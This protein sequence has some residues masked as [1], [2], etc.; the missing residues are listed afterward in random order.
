[1]IGIV[2]VEF[3]IDWGLPA[4][5]VALGLSALFRKRWLAILSLLLAFAWFGMAF[6]RLERTAIGVSQGRAWVVQTSISTPGHEIAPTSIH[7]RSATSM[8]Q[9]EIVRIGDRFRQ[10][11]LDRNIDH[12]SLQIWRRDIFRLNLRSSG[13]CAA[14]TRSYTT[15]QLASY[16]G[17]DPLGRDRYVETPSRLIS[18]TSA[19]ADKSN[20]IILTRAEGIDS[21]I[22]ISLSSK[23]TEKPAAFGYFK[24]YSISDRSQNEVYAILHGAHIDNRALRPIIGGNVKLG[25]SHIDTVL[26]KY[27]GYNFP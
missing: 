12:A 6:D 1:M 17:H 9:W 2:I 22:V 4:A 3:W 21:D 27:L 25:Y 26:E 14:L 24:K 10:L 23:R 15:K 5:L 11:M 7:F 16:L 20:C 8:Y 18:G 19:T 13:D